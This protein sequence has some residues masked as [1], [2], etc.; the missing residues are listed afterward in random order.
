MQTEVTFIDL[1]VDYNAIQKNKWSLH[2]QIFL[3]TSLC[4]AAQAWWL[5]IYTQE[6]RRKQKCS[7][8]FAETEQIKVNT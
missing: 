2:T 6:D 4:N 8:G 3:D 7:K 5:T 1:I